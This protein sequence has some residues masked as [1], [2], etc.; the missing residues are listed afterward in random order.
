VIIKLKIIINGLDGGGIGVRFEAG[1]RDFSVLHKVQDGSQAH[2]AS[3]IEGA[4]AISLGAKR[5]GREA[6]RSHLP[7][8]EVKNGG[9]IAPYPC[10]SS[11]CGA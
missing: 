4:G 11:W 10:T 1:A 8:A 2:P 5:L 7:C 9:T 3:Y 6:D